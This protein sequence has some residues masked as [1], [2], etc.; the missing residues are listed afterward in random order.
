MVESVIV[1]PNCKK[2]INEQAEVQIP[3]STIPIDMEAIFLPKQDMSGVTY[4]NIV[5]K[6]GKYYLV[7]E[8]IIVCPHCKEE[9]CYDIWLPT[10]NPS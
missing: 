9:F 2:A 3:S 5:L 10:V 4:G 6:D 1:C 8:S 7:F